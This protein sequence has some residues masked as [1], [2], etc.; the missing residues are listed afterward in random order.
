MTPNR[1]TD[2]WAEAAPANAVNPIVDLV[3]I[4]DGG[5]GRAPWTPERFK[6]YVCRERDGRVRL[7]P[8]N[9]HM[10][11]LYVSPA[12]VTIQGVVVGVMRRF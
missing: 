3:L 8:A 7:Q 6:P 12:D 4:Y 1:V 10:Q 5:Q 11:P 2:D 9:E